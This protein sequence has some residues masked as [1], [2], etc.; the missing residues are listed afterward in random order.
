MN[1]D[2]KAASN[3]AVSCLKYDDDTIVMGKTHSESFQNFIESGQAGD[4]YQRFYL[5]ANGELIV[6]RPP[7]HWQKTACTLLQEA[8]KCALVDVGIEEKDFEFIGRLPCKIG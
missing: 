7:N 4:F 1:S 6:F 5:R 8:F 2:E 3:A